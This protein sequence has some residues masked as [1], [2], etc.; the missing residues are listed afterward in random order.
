MTEIWSRFFRPDTRLTLFRIWFVIGCIL[1]IA[2]N[3][4]SLSS[5]GLLP[6]PG[7]MD[8]LYHCIA[9]FSLAYWWFM[10]FPAGRSRLLLAVLF[11][12]MGVMLEVLQSFHPIRHLDVLDMLAN[13]SGV[14]IA[15]IITTTLLQH[16]LYKFE[17]LVLKSSNS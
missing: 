7:H 2:V 6:M 9:Y 16:L 17:S 13:A 12:L 4:W 15:L 11:T 14:V 8:K 1:I 10:L 5:T 3:Y